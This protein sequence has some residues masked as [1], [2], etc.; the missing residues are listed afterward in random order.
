MR[1]KTI[2]WLLSVSM[3]L[4]MFVSAPL[5]AAAVSYTPGNAAGFDSSSNSYI[6]VPDSNSLDV[7]NAL[8]FEAW[9]KPNGGGEWALISGK[10]LNPSDGNPWYSY[11]LLAASAN[12]GEK[13]FPR[14]VAFQIAPEGLGE[15]G[16]ESNTVVQNDVWT[17]VAGVYDG[18]SVK[19]Y[20]NGVL[21]NSNPVTGNIQVS[22][23]PLYIG[24]APWTNYNNYNGLIDEVRVWNVARTAE[25]ISYDMQYTLTGSESGLVSYWRFDESSGITTADATGNN[26]DG[27]LYNL[28]YFTASGAPVTSPYDGEYNIEAG[29]VTISADGDY[30]I[31]GTGTSTVNTIVVNTGV[32]ANIVL[33]NVNINVSGTSDA[34]AFDIQGTA[35]VNVALAAGSENTL[36]SGE[37]KAGLQVAN[38]AQLTI[39]SDVA[40]A[41]ILNSYSGNYGAGI[42]G[43][44]QQS[45]GSIIIENG[46]I[47]ANASYGSGAGIGSGLYGDDC[48][49]TIN[50]GNIT[51]NGSGEGAG[52][53]SGGGGDV[54]II[55]IHGGTVVA[56]S[57]A[58]EASYEGGSGIGSGDNGYNGEILIDGGTITASGKYD[59]PGIGG[60]YGSTGTITIRGAGTTVTASSGLYAAAIGGGY[61][62][63]GGV[64][65]IEG[66]TVTANGR[67][68][69]PGIG[70][71]DD[72]TTV[73]NISG[74]TV[75]SN[76]GEEACGIGSGYY[77]N[78]LH[79]QGLV[80]ILNFSGGRLS[81]SHGVGESYDINADIKT[82]EGG[83]FS[84]GGTLDPAVDQV[85]SISGSVRGVFYYDMNGSGESDTIITTLTASPNGY[86]VLAPLETG[87]QIFRQADDLSWE[88]AADAVQPQL[89]AGTVDRTSDSG[90]DITFSC[91]EFAGFFY[92]VTADG[93]A[94]PDI[95]TTGSG[96]YCDGETTLTINSLT[97]GAWDIYLVA[98]DTAGNE[99]IMIKMDIGANVPDVCKIGATGYTSLADAL[100][101]VTTGQTITLLADI[102][103][104]EQ[105]W[106]GSSYR[107]S[108]NLDLNGYELNISNVE[109][110]I[111]AL[112]GRY[113]NVLD[114]SV[115]GGGTLILNTTSDDS[116]PTGIAA[117]G[118]GSSV[119][120]DSEVEATITATGNNSKGIYAGDGGNVEIRNGTI[121]GDSVGVFASYSG[122]VTVY[123]DVF[124]TGGSGYGVYAQNSGTVTVY[125]NV[126]V[127][128][129]GCYG[130]WAAYA[131]TVKID[132]YIDAYYYI[133]LGGSGRN[134]ENFVLPSTLAGYY[135]YTDTE[136]TVWIKLLQPGAENVAIS[137]SA[138]VGE[139]LTGSYDYIQV[140][141][142]SEGATSFRWLRVSGIPSLLGEPYLLFTTNNV[143]G[144]TNDPAGPPNPA[145]FTVTDS[146]VITKISNYHYASSDTPGTISLQESGGAVYGPWDAVLDGY[147]R[148]YPNITVPAGT[149]T[150]IDSKSGSWSFNLES[151]NA[152]MTEIVGYTEI[153]G[154]TG[155]T[156]VL[157]DDDMGK[158]LIFEVTPEN[159]VET[160]GSAVMS[161]PFGP[162]AMPLYSDNANLSNLSASG[163]TLTPAF[164]STTTSYTANVA[165]SNSSTTTSAV[166]SD[167]FATISI[168]D[169]EGS[170]KLIALN[171]GSN[172][173]T[174][175]VTAEDGVTTKTYTI[176]I[177]RAASSPSGGSYTPPAIAVTTDTTD[178]ATSNSI[179]IDPSISSGTASVSVTNA[180]VDALLSKAEET[181]G[182]EKG[183]LI[184]I[185]VDTPADTGKLTLNIPQSELAKIA[186]ET[187]ADFGISS[188]FISIVFDGKAV[189]TISEANTG[190]TVSI[191]ATRI[192]EL[193]GRPVYDLTVMNGST[194]ISD[195][196]GGHATV[197]IPYELKPGEDP[198][199]VVIYYLADDGTLKAVRGH[200][201]ADMKAV[202][203]KTTHFSKFLLGYNPVSFSDVAA[204]A[205]YKNA[206]DFIAARG[207]SSGTG[208][209]TFSPEA[210]L[211]RGQFIV[212][213]MNAY[214]ISPDSAPLGTVN[215]VDAGNTYYTNY[216]LAAKGLGIVN[217]V[218]N[219]Q[220]APE[221]AI[222]RQEM[223]VMLYNALKVIDEVPASLVNKQLSDFSDANQV[224][225]W[226]QD[227]FNALIQGG[228]IS[229]SNGKL[230][231][232]ETTSRAQMAQVLYNLLSK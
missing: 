35:Q 41:G 152:G 224:A 46:V 159:A 26:N 147:W 223:F 2:S 118:L 19:I 25:Q 219:N 169:V 88:D 48:D 93:A 176:T 63:G 160:I 121:R 180:M 203:F 111:A 56:N 170:T 222:T 83:I 78:Y 228:I 103:Y 155:E 227:A 5:T 136:N 82:T 24:K 21:E 89:T 199:A 194:Q 229:G 175:E 92:Q 110:P 101:V 137:G 114:S 193:N 209:G 108:L 62:D 164:N 163:V 87:L 85:I 42:G 59:C 6:T 134:P 126:L 28:A 174:V 129:D 79:S 186:S 64:I 7:T 143:G 115:S 18:T 161:S 84:T 13:G 197:T 66:G 57:T 33:E 17:H 211:T 150:I 40:N 86:F 200:Y 81:V 183:D 38:A 12:S 156:Y 181:G 139:T 226:A 128:H 54:G 189:D 119:L 122:N 166:S 50:G 124:H 205:W 171:V 207:I 69:S 138:L 192:A 98:K 158:S 216:L 148:V 191:T 94:I 179:T 67:Y 52:I 80:S 135:T 204:D 162:V 168:N 165:N 125:G 231:P 133:N 123:G 20:I 68:N 91:S 132:G 36:R 109:V 95:D 127:S 225:S 201:D 206:V 210:T 178:G 187:N 185:V 37:Y 30:R 22:N 182:T 27:N 120:V 32:T 202:V 65:N 151:G 58:N 221:L 149:Y 112:D 100:D 154:T 14:K 217:G 153:S 75:A 8:T 157:Q 230:A 4:T 131:S 74:G 190:G 195:F 96:A 220:Y 167:D 218:G 29:P 117:A 55:H 47:N 113:V 61:G 172:V 44:Y 140:G 212:L 71:Y 208:T 73:I 142:E 60:C 90:A 213:L 146:T 72:G 144:V 53:G 10:Q 105:I 104:G 23:L 31:Y 15:T 116:A 77:S 99:G 184:N 97:A 70:D 214:N 76:G 11:R 141:N 49:I 196:N 107:P 173:I 102:A 145:S 130:V 51:A 106:A 45:G 188:P 215:F 39:D 198:N 9:I 43:A 16:V 177:N 34:C 232:I 3:V 1:K